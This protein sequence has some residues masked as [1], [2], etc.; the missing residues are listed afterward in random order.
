MANPP[1]RITHSDQKVGERFHRQVDERDATV[2]QDNSGRRCFRQYLADRSFRDLL[3]IEGE[4]FVLQIAFQLE[5][6]EEG[7]SALKAVVYFG[8]QGDRLGR[9]TTACL[10]EE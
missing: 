3:G 7:S 6:F 1:F 5:T 2:N 9:A 4:D 10:K 8:R